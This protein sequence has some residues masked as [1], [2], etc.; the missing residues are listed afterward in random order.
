MAKSP[1]E[2]TWRDLE[3][4][5]AVSEP[6]NA[7]SYRTGDWKTFKPV[8]DKEKCIHCGICYLYCPDMAYPPADEEGYFISNLYYCK[9]CGICAHECPT[10]AIAMKEE[11]E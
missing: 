6:G 8:L 7:R 11:E 9:G 10:E 4:G 2:L 3:V 5:C 1:E